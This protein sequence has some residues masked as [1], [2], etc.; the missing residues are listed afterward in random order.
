[1]AKK[2]EFS[3]A[4]PPS[5]AVLEQLADFLVRANAK[6]AG[7]DE[8]TGTVEKRPPGDTGFPVRGSFWTDDAKAS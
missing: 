1:M 3:V 8:V 2:L 6:K 7:M 5:E 4:V